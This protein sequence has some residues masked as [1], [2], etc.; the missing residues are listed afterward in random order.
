MLD[1]KTE[2][3][4]PMRVTYGRQTLVKDFL[5]TLA[6]RTFLPTVERTWRE[7]SRIRHGH[8][9]AISNLLFVRSA[10]VTLDNLKHTRIE[11]EPLRYMTRPI[12]AATDSLREIITVPDKQMDNFIRISEAP[13]DQRTFLSAADLQGHPGDTVV[14]TSGPFAGIEGIINR[15]KGNRR[16]VVEIAGVAGVCIN[17][18][19]SRFIIR[20]E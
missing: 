15:I 6:I 3:W 16:V 1:A 14:V 10:K 11:A 18:V 12:T 17:F 8:V 4:F 20:K 2:Y 13:D 7:G 5:D 9:P 19:P